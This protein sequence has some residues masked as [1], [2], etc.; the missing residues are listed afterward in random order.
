MKKV[1]Q[2]VFIFIVVCLFPACSTKHYAVKSIEGTRVE[3]DST[4]D[5]KADPAIVALVNSYKTKLEAEMNVEIGTAAQTLDKG[6]PQSLLT[7]FT[8]DAMKQFAA[9]KLGGADFGVVNNGGL[10]SVLNKG[11]ITVG[12][13]Y[14]IYSFD[15]QVVLLELPGKAVRELFEYIAVQGGE[16]LSNGVQLVIKDRKIKS[17]KIGGQPLDENKTYRVVTLDYLA[18]GNSG[19]VAF[20]QA[21]RT[22]DPGLTLR[23]VMINHV[24]KCTAEGQVIDAR[25]DD[26]IKI[27][28]D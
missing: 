19:M 7:N 17:L 22:T 14:E 1:D 12:N 11:K 6:Y 28:R 5:A 3:M 16:G 24:K 20:K 2:F 4:W 25:L 15:N 27:E 18:E 10:R 13:L 21:V 23:D 8:T 26:R 9:E